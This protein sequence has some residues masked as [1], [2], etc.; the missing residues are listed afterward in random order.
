MKK[1]ISKIL[2]ILLSI[3]I[4]GYLVYYFWNHP[5]VI[6]SVGKISIWNFVFLFIIRST[7]N[8]IYSIVNHVIIRKIR[9]DIPLFDNIALQFANQLLNKVIPKGGAAFRGVYLKEVY[10]FPY[11]KFIST[12]SGLYVITFSS[13][14][15]TAFITFLIIYLSTGKYNIYFILAFLV[16]FVLSI[17]FIILP[18]DFFKKKDGRVYKILNSILEG[19]SEIRKDLQSVF[20]LVVMNITILFFNAFQMQI[21]YK[22]IGFETT[23]A[24][25]LFLSLVSLL[26]I[27]INITPDGIGVKESIFAFSSEMVSIPADYLV[28]GSLIERAISWSIGMIFGG[29]SYLWLLR[30][31]NKIKSIQRIDL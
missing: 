16:V 5:E 1:K 19:W 29:I 30:K 27:F 24:S 13:Y 8:F 11:S 15:L 4:I 20:L 26:T 7:I 23:F 12:I 18:T 2:S 10:Q 14:A 6:L 31:Y 28:L 25:F 22:S 9:P 21:I 17:L 3:L